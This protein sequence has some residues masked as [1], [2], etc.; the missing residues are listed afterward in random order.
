[1]PLTT[2][3]G[4]G[5][6]NLAYDFDPGTGFLP[7]GR[8]ACTWRE[9][10]AF[11]VTDQRFAR[12]NT[13]PDLWDNLERFLAEYVSLETRYSELMPSSLVDRIWLA[14]SFVSA[15]LDPNNTD[16][17][18]VFN[19]DAMHAV[20]GNEG[21]GIL[22]KSRDH[23]KS[24]YQVAMVPLEYQP[25]LS[26]FRPKA[27]TQA[28]E[29]YY[30]ER[31]RWDDWWQRTRAGSATGEPTLQTAVPRRGYLEVSLDD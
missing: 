21:A 7:P 31:G 23:W 4:I 8:Y 1:M 11:L 14:G 10:K 20:R 12:S 9:A 27:F 3:Q 19:Q 24:R 5:H 16:V 26:A 30:R 17:T 2:A 18:V 29:Q 15:K 28:D 22:K 13:R 25:V 6:H